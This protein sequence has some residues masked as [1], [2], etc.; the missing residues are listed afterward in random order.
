[1]QR[2][3]GFLNIIL[4]FMVV[5][6]IGLA[7][8]PGASAYTVGDDGDPVHEYIVEQAFTLFPDHGLSNLAKIQS[9]A[10]HEDLHDHVYDRSGAC[11]TYTHFWDLDEGIDDPVDCA[12]GSCGTGANAWQKVQI[13]WGMAIGEY[14]SGDI[15]MGYHYLGHVCHLLADMSVPAHVHEDVHGPEPFEDDCYE[16]WMTL[17]HAQLSDIEKAELVLQG[18]VVVP[19]GTDPLFYLFYTVNQV[20]DFFASDALDGDPDDKW[21]GWMHDVYTELGMYSLTSP[22]T[23]DDLSDNDD[24]DDDD[25]GDLSVV[26]NYSYK[27]GIR[28]TATLLKY[29]HDTVTPRKALTVVID[30]V[31]AKDCHDEGLV[32]PDCYA[33]FFVEVSID[34]A[35]YRN[36]GDQIVDEDGISPGWAFGRDV[37][38][39]GSI[40]IRILLWDEDEEGSPGGDD[41][42]SDIDPQLPEGERQLNFWVDLATGIISGEDVSGTCGISLSVEGECETDNDESIM[43]FTVILPNI[44]PTVTVEDDKTVDEGDT[45]T[46]TG[47]FTDPNTD[48]SWT[49]LWHLENSTNGQVIDDA[50]GSAEPN[51]PIDFTFT[52]CDNGIYTFSLTVTDSYG[53]SD[54]DEVVVTVLNMPPTVNTPDISDQDNAEFILPMVH[55]TDF[56]GDFTDPGTCDTHTATWDWSDGS[57][58]EGN[59]TET[60]GSGSVTGSHIFSVPGDF[61]VTLTVTDDDGDIGSNTMNVH[62]ADVGEALDIFNDYI[63]S[64][65]A[66]V[67]KKKAPQSK[68]AFDNMFIALDDMLADLEYQGMI[69]F[70]NSNLRTTFDGLVG[71]STK[72]DW[73]IEEVAIQTELCQK[74]DDISSYLQYLLSNMP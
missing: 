9:G 36:E 68:K 53:A 34:S 12:E 23:T 17:A 18:P 37:G 8:S 62:I 69:K 48:D 39:S 14:L 42:L 1:M 25:D 74:V 61:A 2:S 16:D 54:T 60:D 49:Y 58:S 51:I 32:E 72:D 20:A 73:I 11:T 66:S 63:Q 52:P 46:L 13:L 15:E 4:T 67:F 19:E 55:D 56:T 44:P 47:S 33:D 65:P 71:G 59:L 31:V 64:L 43:A 29:F 3:K 26:R 41:D 40:P 21:C 70:L 50:T 22:L 7:C 38:V 24:G 10:E 30:N 6:L 27:F 45:V 35:W 5:M 57:P 28:A